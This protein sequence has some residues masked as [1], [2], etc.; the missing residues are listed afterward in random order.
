METVLIFAGG[1]TVDVADE[2]PRP[3]LVVAADGG[4]DSAVSLGFRVDVLVGDLDSLQATDIP[5][6]VIVERHATNKDATDLDLALELVDREDPARV[7]VVGGAGGRVDHEFATVE[8]LCGPRW[9]NIGELD[10]ISDRGLAHVIRDSRE[11]HG[12]AGELISLIPVGGDVTGVVTKGLQWNLAGETLPHGTTRGVSNVFA[13]PV[14]DV[15]IDSGCLLA[16]VAR[17]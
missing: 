16:V 1:D 10:W 13:G 11:I 4:Y 17:G 12:D 6:H 9:R 15:R 7:I 2:L 3:D 14:A 8:L 5:D